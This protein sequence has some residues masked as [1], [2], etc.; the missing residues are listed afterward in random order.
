MILLICGLLNAQNRVTIEITSSGEMKTGACIVINAK[1]NNF[2][3]EFAMQLSKDMTNSDWFRIENL[4]FKEDVNLSLELDD[5]LTAYNANILIICKNENIFTVQAYDALEKTMLFEFA[6]NPLSS[7]VQMA[8]RVNDEIVFR[9]TGKPGMATSKI[10]Y[11]TKKDRIYD[12]MMADYDGSNPKSLLS[13]RFII[14]YPRW[15][16]DKKKVLFLS[17]RK[18]FPY[19]EYIDITTRQIETFLSEPGLNACASFFRNKN[20]AAVVLSKSGKP[21]IYLVDMEGNILKRLTEQK[22]VN[23]SP[24]ISPD[25]EKI[26]FVSDK[27][28]RVNLLGKEFFRI[29]IRKLPIQASYIAAPVWSPDGQYL[30]YAVRYGTDMYIEIYQWST[31][32]RHILTENFSLSDAPSW[33]PDSRHIIFTRQQNY[34]NSL[35]SIDIY[36]LTLRKIAENAYSPCWDVR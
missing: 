32:K 22:G 21:D 24:A 27:D 15:F 18:T 1:K 31:G 29:N 11:I 20:Q 14:N 2:L 5:S 13:A 12:L 8:H 9:L 28:G 6:L 16:P 10:L 33:A 4:S 26:V 35:W 3:E 36:C 23:A 25:G 7:A 34:V 30:A 19:L 17:Y